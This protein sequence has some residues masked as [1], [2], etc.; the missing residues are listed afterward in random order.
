MKHLQNFRKKYQLSPKADLSSISV[1]VESLSEANNI[2]FEYLA[3]IDPNDSKEGFVIQTHLNILGRIFE[4]SMGMLVCIATKCPTSSEA[5]ARVVVE[6]SINL[7]YMASKGN[8]STL[9]GFIDS[10]LVEHKKKLEEWKVKI[11][12]KVYESRVTPMI[13]ERLELINMYEDFVN[14]IVD[15]CEISRKPPRE[16]W[17]KSLFERFSELGRETDYYES[18]HR[19]SGSSHLSGEDTLI[20]TITLDAS[21]EHKIEVAQEA[22]AYST[23]MSRIAGTFFI[24]AASACCS[25]HGYSSPEVFEKIITDLVKTI[26]EIADAAGV[27]RSS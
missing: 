10:W 25:A 17:P 11:R 1:A 6:G 5:I 8:E 16:V 2:A 26:T 20:W 7:M 24:D 21:L 13:V 3:N 22:F 12:D 19:L 15:Q 27:P 18:Y 9:I 14:Q 4:Q 23:M